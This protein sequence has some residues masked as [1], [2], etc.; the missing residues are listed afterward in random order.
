M[1]TVA[2]ELV[3]N[4]FVFFLDEFIFGLDVCSVLIVMKEV[5]KVV[6]LGCMVISIIY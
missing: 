6:V 2:V 4:V 5:K 1:F 3:L